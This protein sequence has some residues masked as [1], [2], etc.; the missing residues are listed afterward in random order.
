M[1]ATAIS[2]TAATAWEILHSEDVSLGDVDG[3]GDLDA[4]VANVVL[5]FPSGLRLTLCG[6][7]TA[8]VTSPIAVTAWAMQRARA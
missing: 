6:S 1:T 4:F 2:A 7:M 8:T 3:D 5:S